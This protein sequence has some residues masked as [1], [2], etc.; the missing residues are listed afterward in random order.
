MVYVL[1]FQTASDKKAL[2][3]TGLF[4]AGLFACILIAEL[5]TIFFFSALGVAAWAVSADVVM[6]SGNNRSNKADNHLLQVRCHP[7]V[8]LCHHP[9]SSSTPGHNSIKRNLRVDMP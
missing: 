4:R 6:N 7:A 1:D 2:F 5:T 8:F 9:H 3:P